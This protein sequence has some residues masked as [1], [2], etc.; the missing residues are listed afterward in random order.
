MKLNYRYGSIIGKKSMRN[1]DFI[2]TSEIMDRFG[3]YNQKIDKRGLLF[4][5][6][7][8][9]GGYNSGHIA[10]KKC[11]EELTQRF[12]ESDEK[13]EDYKKWFSDELTKIND[14]LIEL[15]EITDDFD[16]K[17]TTIVSLVIKKD[18][19]FVV[20]IGDSRLYI[21]YDDR[22]V[23]ITEDRTKVWEL[24]KSGRIRKNDLIRFPEKNII[25]QAV[26]IDKDI[27]INF[28]K[29]DLLEK[30]NIL[31]FRDGLTDVV[32]DTDLKI[33]FLQ[34]LDLEEIVD[35]LHS[36]A[37]RNR[38]NDDISLIIVTNYLK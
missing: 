9:I 6:C 36:L 24:F 22:F 28:Y 32:I 2:L 34:T 19:A 13:I 3:I 4:V 7:D 1:E 30:Y 8:G 29:I 38:S 25:T 11:A 12:Y 10:S 37:L 21:N 14:I 17:G 26:G 15:G 5:L 18:L 27:E 20:N 23:Q 33:V 35:N 31:M 16:K